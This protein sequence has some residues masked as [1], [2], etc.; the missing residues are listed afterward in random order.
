MKAQKI[1]SAIIM[2]L[3][4]GHYSQLNAQ[5]NVS[6]NITTNTTWAASKSP[7]TLVGT[8]DVE[9][10]VTLT[11]DS[12]V[13]VIMQNHYLEVG[14]SNS[15]ILQANGVTFN[16]GTIWFDHNSVGTVTNCSFV[17]TS[18]EF[19]DAS[20]PTVTN[21]TFD[22]N[23][24]VYLHSQGVI[25][26][27]SGNSF[28]SQ[29]LYLST[30]FTTNTTLPNYQGCDYYLDGT[31]DIESGVTLTIAS[32][33]SIVMQ[34]HYLEVG[35]SNSSILQ[36]NGVTFNNGTI[37]FDHTSVGTVT[38]CS[39]VNT[40]I[41]FDDASSPTVTNNTFDQNSSVY[42]HSQGVIPNMSGNSFGS[43]KLYLSTTFT[44]NTTLPNYQGCD[45][46]LDGTV[47]IESGVTLTIASGA[48]IVMQNHYLEVGYSNSSIL[49]ANGVT[50]NNGTI[51]FDHNSV[52]TVT[53]CSF[54]N[55]SI[56]F[57][58]ASSPTVTNNT[59]DQNSS[60]YLHS[61]GVIPNMSGNSFGSQKLY[62]S[63]TFTTNTTLPNY[64]G[65]D[66]YLDGT[67]DIESGVTLTIASGASIVMQNHY[68]EVGYS[69]SSILQANSVTFN[70]GTIWFDHNSTGTIY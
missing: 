20:S 28:G 64:Q 40:S 23:S 16:N 1:L 41:E 43:Q 59:F 34:N 7:Y 11:I 39:F 3:I 63:T 58:D 35:Y 2:T 51:W 26:N 47:D 12:G 21:N 9:N 62:L 65:C 44:T 57:D 13:T 37:W 45:Y 49:Q 36:A 56:E 70:N 61:Q 29:K 6:G 25:P 42:L 31:V 15:S 8:V 53:N 38:N 30:T 69:N 19:D 67:V 24:S 50:F 4:V 54:V 60:V 55:T 18:I 32:G 52:G 14:Y 68:L 46:Y 5:T 22:Q 17:N 33:A 10:G 27:M 66:Y 48:S